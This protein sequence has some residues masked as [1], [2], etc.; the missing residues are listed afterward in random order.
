[1][2][3]HG[4]MKWIDPATATKEIKEEE[5]SE[6]DIVEGLCAKA[7]LSQSIGFE[8]KNRI[9]DCTTAVDIWFALGD[10]F[11]YNSHED[12]QRLKPLLSQICKA[13]TED[14]DTFIVRFDELTA[15]ARNAISD[16]LCRLDSV[17][18]TSIFLNALEYSDIPG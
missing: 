9:C 12:E 4:W 2:E 15:Q 13:S 3:E 8:H 5:G 16:L 6:T 18:I 14:L 11:G 7:L 17:D 1:L 10:E